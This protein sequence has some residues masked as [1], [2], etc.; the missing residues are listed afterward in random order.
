MM[1][2]YLLLI[3]LLVCGAA[4]YNGEH[5]QEEP[6][7]A[8]SLFEIND[9]DGTVKGELFIT[10]KKVSFGPNQELV[11]GAGYVLASQG[12]HINVV[13]TIAC[14]DPESKDAKTYRQLEI[15]ARRI[16]WDIEGKLTAITG[17]DTLIETSDGDTLKIVSETDSP[18]IKDGAVLLTIE[19]KG[20]FEFFIKFGGY[21][22]RELTPGLCGLFGLL[23]TQPK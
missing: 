21:G 11:S 6:P 22:L 19:D 16:D 5:T 1:S 7:K 8:K 15:H 3:C 10:S 14:Q 13:L 18:P 9:S 2:R 4:S 20:E 12:K 17:V 23:E